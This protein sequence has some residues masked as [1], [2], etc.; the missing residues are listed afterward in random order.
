MAMLL[1]I[2]TSSVN[3]SVS[4]FNKGRLIAC[5]EASRGYSHA[6]KLHP[7]I[8][9]ILEE[10][11]IKTK[12]IQG[13]VLGAGPGSFT[14]LRI[15]SAAS[16]G[17]CFALNIPLITIPSLK[18]MAMSVRSNADQLNLDQK[19]VLCPMI[20]AR[21]MEVYC[22]QFDQDLNQ[23]SEAK[24]LILDEST[25]SDQLSK[26]KIVFFGDGMNKMKGFYENHSNAVFVEEILPTSKVMAEMAE[27]KF[28]EKD[29]ED[30]AYYEPFYLKGFQATTPKKLI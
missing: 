20:D 1:C 14:G 23:I 9:E 21:R 17:L 4:L 28:L 13:I 30:V 11:G 2:E 6:E 15:G 16:K 25:F 18:N 22:A 29:F 24:P 5:R 7:F 19:F 26:E 3:C 27:K 12:E 10:S 8:Q